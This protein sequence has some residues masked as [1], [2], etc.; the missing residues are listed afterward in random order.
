MVLEII[1]IEVIKIR[2]Q[3]EYIANVITWCEQLDWCIIE[4]PIEC[5]HRNLFEI[6]TLFANATQVQPCQQQ[7]RKR[8]QWLIL[9]QHTSVGN[10][11]MDQPSDYC[12]KKNPRGQKGLN[13]ICLNGPINTAPNIQNN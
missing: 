2:M 13:W 1:Q 8:F 6:S 5:W 3:S 7:P 12:M 10:V 11:T 4:A 9:S